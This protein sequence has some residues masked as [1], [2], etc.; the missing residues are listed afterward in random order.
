MQVFGDRL[1]LEGDRSEPP[2]A[3][4]QCRYID[5]M[6]V[7]TTKEHYVISVLFLLCLSAEFLFFITFGVH[8]SR[9]DNRG[10]PFKT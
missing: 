1:L 8:F 2:K 10:E 6:S 9:D 7:Q 4:N 5:V 3:K